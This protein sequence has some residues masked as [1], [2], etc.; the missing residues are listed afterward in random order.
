MNT[1]P[2][3]MLQPTLDTVQQQIRDFLEERIKTDVAVD[4][5]LFDSGLVNSMFAMELV[6][7][8]E[9]RYGVAILGEDLKLDNFRTVE[10]M[11]SLVLRLLD[12]PV[13]DH[14]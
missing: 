4:K 7:H 6:V 3:E 1:K 2:E 12:A 10:R 5:D 11:T 14:A 8:L 9:Q 13:A